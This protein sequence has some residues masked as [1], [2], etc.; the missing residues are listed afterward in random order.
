MHDLFRQ[1]LGIAVGLG[2]CLA[3]R[4]GSVAE[5]LPDVYKV[6]KIEGT[7]LHLVK[8]DLQDPR[9]QVTIQTA[10]GYPRG[11]EALS[12]LLAR[13]R[14]A[15]AVNGSYFDPPSR[16]PIGVLVR[17]GVVRHGGRIGTVLTVTAGNEAQIERLDRHSG[18]DWTTYQTVLCGGPML[19]QDSQVDVRIREEGFTEPHFWRRAHRIGIGVTADRRLLIVSPKPPVT[20]KHFARLMRVLGCVSAMNLDGGSSR[21]LYRRGKTHIPARRSLTNLLLIHVRPEQRQ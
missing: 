20:L 10:R 12:R 5:G 18:R 13:S 14:P 11:A 17:D 6:R 8:V 3:I 2:L 16:S 4:Q 1:S 7:P 19:V 9:V 21:A 15:L